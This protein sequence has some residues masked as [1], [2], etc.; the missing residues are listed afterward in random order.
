MERQNNGSVMA[1]RKNRTT[2]KN[3]KKSNLPRARAVTRHSLVTGRSRHR[4]V[5]TVEEKK[6]ASFRRPSQNVQDHTKTV[7][8]RFIRSSSSQ[9]KRQE[10]PSRG[11]VI[12]MIPSQQQQ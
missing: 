9:E 11:I 12:D 4:T 7:S 2:W 10:C 5:T 8:D 6:A 1:T 3:G